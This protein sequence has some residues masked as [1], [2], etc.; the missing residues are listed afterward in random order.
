MSAVTAA[1]LLPV[2]G[3]SA[4]PAEGPTG[5]ELAGKTVFLDP[6]HQGSAAGHSLSKQVPNGY[7]ALKDCATTGMETVNGVSEH[8][9]NWNV[10]TIVKGVLESLGAKVEMSRADDTGWGGCIDERAAAAN[11]S[12]AN[13]A[14][15]IHAD[16]TIKGADEA[17]SGFHM[18]IPQL[19]IP[20]AA[21]QA[22]QAG[23]GR[24]ASKLMVDAYKEQ[25]FSPANYAG[26]QDGLMVRNDIAGPALTTVPL[27]FIEM[28]NG[29]NPGDAA[30][31]T[32]VDGQ[33][34]HA[35]AIAR[36]IVSYLFS[37]GQATAPAAAAPAATAPVATAP[38]AT[39]KPVTVTM[40]DGTVTTP[41]VPKAAPAV[42]APAKVEDTTGIFDK[43]DE[44]L[45]LFQK[46]V[47]ADGIDSLL[48]L[49]NEGKLDTVSDFATDVVALLGPLVSQVVPE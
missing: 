6:G 3:A 12:G 45:A 36:G 19:P 44:V 4:A 21:A 2:A 10:A 42:A 9:I 23:G 17:R 47:A 49:I 15:S 40:N 48:A 20:N 37:S 13:V 29:S 26:V 38:A 25:G 35:T 33:Y 31:L 34:K 8:E 28:G 1:M 24:T 16:S 43:M 7:G 39:A 18:I 27:V 46:I 22:A 41:V 5:N 30:K 32:S 14:V 11:K